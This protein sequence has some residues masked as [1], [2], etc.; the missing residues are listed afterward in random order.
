MV[1][2]PRS[3]LATG[4]LIAALVLPSCS[5]GV[6][7]A[8]PRVQAIPAQSTP[9]GTAFSVDLA[10]YVSDRENTALTFRVTDGGG[11]FSGSV[12]TNTFPT[13]G[14]Y[15]VSFEVHDNEKI[16]SATF[17]VRVT[18]A[19]LA[20]VKEDESGLL[21]LDT[22]TEQFVRIGASVAS[23]RFAVAL[24]DGKVLYNLGQ[25]ATQTL[26]VFDPV[27]RAGT[28]LGTGHVG[29]ATYVTKTSAGLVLFTC[30]DNSDLD[31]YSYNPTNGLVRA[32]SANAGE[33]DRNPMVNSSDLVFFERG[34]GG[35]TDIYYYDPSTNSS[36]AVSTAAAGETLHAVLAD[37][38][39]VF[40][41]IENGFNQLFYYRQDLGMTAVPT[42]G[43]ATNAAK[44]YVGNTSSSDVI[45]RFAD[46]GTPSDALGWWNVDGTTGRYAAS[47][48]T[49][50]MQL[51]G[52][53]ANRELVLIEEVSG[54]DHDLYVVNTAA[55]ALFSLDTAD[56]VSVKAVSTDG[57]N[58]YVVYQNSITTNLHLRNITGA[59]TTT[60]SDAA[61]LTLLASLD[62]ADLVYQK[63]DGSSL[64]VYDVSAATNNTAP[65]T[66]MTYAG[67]GTDA[68]DVVFTSELGGQTDLFLWDASAT[69]AVIV[70]NDAADDTFQA[71]AVGGKILFTRV[72]VDNALQLHVFDPSDTT[73]EQLT[74]EDEL[75][76]K[77]DFTV[78]GVFSVN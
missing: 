75:S 23:P 48:G 21:L 73:T 62:N 38:G 36:V 41:R 27:T 69:S 59:A 30:G 47:T 31:L 16:T 40:S 20:L 39:I 26:W 66:G 51:A 63:A 43:T 67:A 32:I 61:G 11:S 1:F 46:A 74:D 64:S 13:I 6:G 24:S 4:G 3:I 72:D 45:Y 14:T 68:G 55:T 34:T 37:G 9:G 10:S 22:G 5:S 44:T 78:L 71:V 76:Q 58:S 60:L 56:I 17:E 50:T 77:H 65:G 42:L 57:T 8:G 35:Q 18:S 15:T 70:S 25:Q 29:A 28:Q 52:T 12:Y 53:T 33:M 54:T 49:A 7:N 2:N 19:N